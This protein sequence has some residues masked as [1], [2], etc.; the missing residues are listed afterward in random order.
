M[1]LV[2]NEQSLRPV[3]LKKVHVTNQVKYPPLLHEAATLL[4][5][6]GETFI[7]FFPNLLSEVSWHH[8]LLQLIAAFLRSMAGGARNS[9][10]TSR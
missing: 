3:A 8:H 9:L 4:R 10:N 1:A 7:L 2:T 5:I 6:R